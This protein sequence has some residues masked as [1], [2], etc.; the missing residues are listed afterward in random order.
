MNQFN[1]EIA[2][3]LLN[4]CNLTEAFRCQLETIINAL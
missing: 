3:T 1:K 4:N 2:E